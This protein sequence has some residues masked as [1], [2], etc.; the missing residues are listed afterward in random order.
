[1][2]VFAAAG[3]Q[4]ERVRQTIRRQ[5]YICVD[6]A[7]QQWL[8]RS[9]LQRAVQKDVVSGMVHVLPNSLVHVHTAMIV[10]PLREALE[11]A[12]ESK[13]EAVHNWPENW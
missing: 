9:R 3:E 12:L 10:E 1:M 5:G 8:S 7:T 2:S 11:D 13:Q 6:T 4:E